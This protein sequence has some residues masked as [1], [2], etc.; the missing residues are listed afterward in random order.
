MIFTLPD[1]LNL[2]FSRA[3]F[4]LDDNAFATGSCTCT[5]T[6]SWLTY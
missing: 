5:F 6:I 2:P 4:M 1:T 3:L